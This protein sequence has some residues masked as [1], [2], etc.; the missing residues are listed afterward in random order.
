MANFHPLFSSPLQF[1]DSS[2]QRYLLSGHFEEWCLCSNLTFHNL[3]RLI[4][5]DPSPFN[6]RKYA[7]VKQYRTAGGHPEPDSMCPEVPALLPLQ[8]GEPASD[9][10]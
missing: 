7:S 9:L 10:M 3:Q 6:R 8:G 2:R 4:F 1:Q 5:L